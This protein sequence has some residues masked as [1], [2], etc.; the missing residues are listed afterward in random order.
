M[1][2]CLT[3]LSLHH[4]RFGSSNTA[5]N[6]QHHIWWNS[7]PQSTIWTTYLKIWNWFVGCYFLKT[8]S[9]LYI[10]KGTPG[11]QASMVSIEQ[12]TVYIYIENH[13][14]VQQFQQLLRSWMPS[15]TLPSVI[16]PQWGCKV[17]AL[18]CKH[19]KMLALQKKHAKDIKICFCL[20]IW[21]YLG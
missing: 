2:S 19:L 1:Y 11:S 3:L 18:T 15:I 5:S 4:S 13:H 10:S 14:N 9:Q 8:V 12:I 7:L 6:N 21:W 17:L 20:L 16:H